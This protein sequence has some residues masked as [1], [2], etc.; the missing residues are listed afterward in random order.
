M[1]FL[2]SMI[3]ALS[4]ADLKDFISQNLWD[5]EPDALLQKLSVSSTVDITLQAN[6]ELQ[7]VSRDQHSFA[8]WLEDYG[9]RIPILAPTE[10]RVLGVASHGST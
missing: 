2:P 10:Y 3:E 5:Y 7:K 4:A 9:S 1:F 8:Q 6:I